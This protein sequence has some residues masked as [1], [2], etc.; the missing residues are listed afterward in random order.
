MLTGAGASFPAP[1]YQ[2]WA[3]EYR[4]RTGVQVNYQAIGSGGGIQQVTAATV[5]FGA[6]DVPMTEAELAGAGAEIL[7]VPTAFGAVAVVYHLPGVPGG[8][9]LTPEV[10]AGIFLGQV[11][12]WNDPALAATNPGVVLPQEA[13]TVVHRSDG[14]GTTAVFSAYLSAASGTWRRLVGAGKELEWPTGVGGKGN[15]GVAALVRLIPGA[16]GYVELAYASQTGL[17]TAAVRNRAGRFV[18]PELA[19][20]SAA[21]ADAQVPDDLRFSVVN[22]PG[23]HAYPLAAATWLLV[24]RQQADP[25]RAALLVRFLWWAIHD[26]QRYNEP[27]LYAQLPPSLVARAERQLRSV[28]PP[29]ALGEAGR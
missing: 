25:A 1:L 17:A 26:G 24:R 2:R 10:L 29:S 23:V 16:I 20:V 4:R 7:H 14:S 18:R 8:L 15:E 22:A 27:L 9:R 3:E 12:V 19:A 28:T 21:A 5:D 11:T 13:I 6:T